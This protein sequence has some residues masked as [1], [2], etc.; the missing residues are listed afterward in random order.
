MIS[1]AILH[2]RADGRLAI[3]TTRIVFI[4]HWTR[5][6]VVTNMVRQLDREYVAVMAAACV[7]L[8]GTSYHGAARV[9]NC[10]GIE[11]PDIRFPTQPRCTT[12]I[13]TVRKQDQLGI[14]ETELLKF[15]ADTS[16]VQLAC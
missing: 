12:A 6:N 11:W 9:F 13:I 2:G 7:A 10:C 16:R 8:L 4:I 1:A 3:W 15:M 5:T 14:I